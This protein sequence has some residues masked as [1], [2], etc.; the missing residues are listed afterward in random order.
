MVSFFKQ[1]GQMKKREKRRIDEKDQSKGK[2]TELID[3]SISANLEKVKQKA[4]NS[5][6]IMIRK[7]KISQ[8]PEIKT[9]I[10]YVQ[11]LIDN[12]SV[13]RRWYDHC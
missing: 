2:T 10:L 13:R 7:L 12:T 4:G 6:D 11:G 1:K 8:N 3:S 9:T 5:P